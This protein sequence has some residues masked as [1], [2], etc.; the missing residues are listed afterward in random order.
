MNRVIAPVALAS[1]LLAG[2]P[3]SAQQGGGSWAD[4]QPTKTLMTMGY[5]ISQPLGQFNDYV[6]G[7]SFRGLSFDWRSFLAKS[8]SAGVRFN[9]NRYNQDLLQVTQTT[10]TGG[11][12]SGPTFHFAEQFA[13]QAIG[14]Y[15]FDTGPDSFL[16]PFVGLGIGGTWFNAR[17][18]TID[19]VSS[20]NDF[21]FTTTPELGLT[22]NLAR[23]HTTASLYFSVLYAFTTASFQ[24]VGNAKALTETIGA[25]FSY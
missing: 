15:Y 19:L 24:N 3:A 9:W 7:T 12:V 2:W 18:Q 1:V 21:Y 13:V 14:H 4:Y 22:L 6:G 11:T 16:F 8:F 17:Q 25:S 23:G 5:Q 20:Q 10:S